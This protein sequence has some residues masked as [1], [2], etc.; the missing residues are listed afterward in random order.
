MSIYSCTRQ[1]RISAV[2]VSD[3]WRGFFSADFLALTWTFP[4]S[5]SV[6]GPSRAI[7]IAK[8]LEFGLAPAVSA[9]QCCCHP[10]LGVCWMMNYEGWGSSAASLRIRGNHD[11]IVLRHN[12]LAFKCTICCAWW[13]SGFLPLHWHTTIGGLE[14]WQLSFQFLWLLCSQGCSRV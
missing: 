13:D 11:M 7:L 2:L 5:H 3:P 14:M 8:N 9:I 4:V 10:H 6:S 12:L 1:P